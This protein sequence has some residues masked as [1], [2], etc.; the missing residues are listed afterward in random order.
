M[1]NRTI[2]KTSLLAQLEQV[3]ADL[4]VV[5][6]TNRFQFEF[7]VG[8]APDGNWQSIIISFVLGKELRNLKKVEVLK[9]LGSPLEPERSTDLWVVIRELGTPVL[10]TNHAKER[11]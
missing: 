9:L 4:Y 6:Q 10:A 7:P 2:I 8:V 11:Y 1:S 5:I 3:T